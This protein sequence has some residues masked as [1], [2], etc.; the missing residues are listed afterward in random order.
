MKPSRGLIANDGAIPISGRQDVI[1]P[2]TKTV[3]DAAYMLSKM[4]GRSEKDD[5]TWSIPFDSIP[6]FTTYCK[7]T[8]L[9]G[10]T[11]GVPRNTFS[12]DPTSPIM[13]SFE[14]A[15]ETLRRAGAKVVDSAD[16]PEADGFKKLNQQVRG[17]VRSSEFKRD[18]VRY[19]QTLETNPNNIKSAEDIIEFTK[20]FAAEEYPERDIGKFLWTQAEGVD[21]DSDKYRDM[22]NQEQFYGGEGGILGAMEK[23]GL[24]LLMVPSS[25]GI[26]NDLAAKM[27]FPVLGVPLGFYPE[28]TPVELDD[29]KPHLVRVAPGIPYVEPRIP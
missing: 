29:C 20:T 16:F 21:V 19:L 7:G 18:I 14:S 22:V 9:T 26:A 12:A 1:G 10:I 3:R 11:V 4:A 27:G 2:I 8:D 25:L 5:R 28:G 24:D 17:I 13:V 15:I 23:H 6:D